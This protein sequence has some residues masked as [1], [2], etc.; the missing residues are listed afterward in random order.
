MSRADPFATSTRPSSIKAFSNSTMN[1][2][3]AVE[4]VDEADHRVVRHAAQ[5]VGSQL[6]D[7]FGTQ[8]GEGEHVRSGQRQRAGG[9]V[10]PSGRRG[11][12]PEDRAIRRQLAKGEQCG[13]I[14]VVHVVDRDDEGRPGRRLREA[15]L[16]FSDGD[17]MPVRHPR[18]LAQGNRVEHGLAPSPSASKSG[19]NDD[20]VRR[21]PP[22]L[23]GNEDRPVAP[24]AAPSPSGSSCPIRPG[25]R[26]RRRHLVRVRGRGPQRRGR[27]PH[28][29]GHEAA[30]RR[31]A[32][33]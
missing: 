23:A 9:R 33:S 16:E 17:M 12:Y 20:P 1:A 22:S 6:A 3:M 29:Y 25:P 10:G 14:S 28:G 32:Q 4:V 11:Q 21:R 7:R 30:P 31:V 15:P 18:H 19:F 8:R 5:H 13:V 2:G 27:R 24:T 26:S